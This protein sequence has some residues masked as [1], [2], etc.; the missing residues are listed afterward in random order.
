MP[1]VKCNYCEELVERKIKAIRVSCITC[2]SNKRKSY[3]KKYKQLPESREKNRNWTK[4]WIKRNST[5]FKATTK[6]WRDRNKEKNRLIHKNC[7]LKSNFG[8][9]LE[10]FNRMFKEQNGK[11]KIC[12]KG[13]IKPHVDHNHDTGKVR[14]LLCNQCNRG[15]GFFNDNYQLL[16]KALYYIK[17]QDNFI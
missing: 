10:D 2:S 15:L 16:D 8:I 6:A 3:Q 1:L 13:L 7:K 12:S 14:G 11:C 4:N 17:C 9:T 5:R